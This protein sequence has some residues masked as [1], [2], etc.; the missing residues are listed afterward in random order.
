MINNSK[1]LYI[2]YIITKKLKTGLTIKFI[3]YIIKLDIKKL[4]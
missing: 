1:Y 4:Q 3:G 2:I